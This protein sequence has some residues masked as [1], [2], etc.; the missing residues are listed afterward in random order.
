MKL[1]HEFC[2]SCNELGKDNGDQHCLSCLNPTY[3]YFSYFNIFTTNCV[4]YGYYYDRENGK[5]EKCADNNYKY[6]YNKTD[7]NK[8]ICFKYDYECPAFYSYFNKES[9]ECINYL[10]LFNL[11]YSASI[12]E[13][14][15]SNL[16]SIINAYVFLDIA[17]TLK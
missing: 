2:S 5:L 6:Y 7:N 16:T 10:D 8:K 17:K 11:D 3:D 1:C 4:P 15:I 9:N 13:D 12:I 14:V